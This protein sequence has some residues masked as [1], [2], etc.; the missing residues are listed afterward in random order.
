MSLASSNG[1]ERTGKLSPLSVEPPPM[2]SSLARP[3]IRELLL[4]IVFQLGFSIVLLGEVVNATRGY[5]TV[6]GQF[7]QLL[8][9]A[10]AVGALVVAYL[11]RTL[12]VT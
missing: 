2:P 9:A 8:G 12:E 7:G 4:V 1:V 11:G 5:D 10:L 3:S 6:L